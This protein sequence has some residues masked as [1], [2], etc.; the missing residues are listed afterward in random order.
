MND[1]A[2]ALLACPHCGSDLEADDPD[3]GSAAL[4]CDRGHTFDV[5]RQGYVSLLS[6]SGGKIVGDS[7]EMV[8]ARAEFLDRGHYDPLM[9]AV[10]DAVGD[11][12]RVLDVGVGTGHYL[13]RVL[14]A[15]VPDAV[16]VGLDVS[17][18][19]ARR[20]AKSHPRAS[21][22]VADVW[23]S[24]PVRSGVIDAA[25]SVFSPRNAE[26]LARVLAPAGVLVV[27]TP[28]ERHLVE[29]VDDLGLVRVDENKT[30]RLGDTLGGRFERV[31]RVPITYST[32]LSRDEIVDVVSMGPSARHIPAA[33][34][35]ARVD[36]MPPAREVTVS[37][38]LGVYARAAA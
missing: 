20:A 28:T 15:G 17:K 30:Q 35:R 37:V 33:D 12:R 13:A 24:I 25:L 8:A 16:G 22:V 11:R 10:A 5:A 7:T 38:T 21:A 27:L 18:A 4:L 19:A 29:L 26:E 31:R 2:V 32:T 1:D 23:Q 6:G 36:E 3:S 14:D 9:D 34:L